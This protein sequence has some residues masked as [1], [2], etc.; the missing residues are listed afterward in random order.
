MKYNIV[1]NHFLNDRNMVT[2]RKIICELDF[3]YVPPF[4]DWRGQGM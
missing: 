4:Y 1:L 3:K 2:A